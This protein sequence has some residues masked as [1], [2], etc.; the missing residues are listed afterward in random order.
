MFLEQHKPIFLNLTQGQISDLSSTIQQSLRESP[1]VIVIISST[2][3]CLLVASTFAYLHICTY[4]FIYV[5]TYNIHVYIMCIYIYCRHIPTRQAIIGTLFS[6]AN[7]SI[8][9]TV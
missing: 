9:W 8:M 4:S 6:R 2:H 3:T 7:R 1:K 5:R